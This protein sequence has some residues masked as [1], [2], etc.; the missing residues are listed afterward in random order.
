MELEP[1]WNPGGH[2]FNIWDYLKMEYTPNYSHI[3]GKI[4]FDQ[5][6]RGTLLSDKP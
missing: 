3:K 1:G 2:D 5:W 4:L 6:F